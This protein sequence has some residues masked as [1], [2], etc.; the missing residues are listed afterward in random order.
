MSKQELMRRV[1]ELEW[2]KRRL[3]EEIERLVRT[4]QVEI[5]G[6]RGELNAKAAKSA[7]E[8]NE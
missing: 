4:H 2:E 1:S 7:K 5:A 3:Q 8:E 6:V